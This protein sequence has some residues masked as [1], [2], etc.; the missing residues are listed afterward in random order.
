MYLPGGQT[1][2]LTLLDPELQTDVHHLVSAGQQTWDLCKSSK[3]LL[4]AEQFLQ[5]FISNS[6]KNAE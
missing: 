1:R 2:T 5:P 4:T 6:I 3:L